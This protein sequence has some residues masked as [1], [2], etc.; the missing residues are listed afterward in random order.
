MERWWPKLKV[1]GLGKNAL[2]DGSRMQALVGSFSPSGASGAAP[3]QASCGM[4]V[5]KAIDSAGSVVAVGA[6]M[7]RVQWWVRAFR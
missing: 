3:G 6:R 4:E 1:V 2:Q 7:C 5:E